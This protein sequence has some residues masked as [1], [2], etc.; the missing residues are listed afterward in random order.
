MVSIFNANVVIGKHLLNFTLTLRTSFSYK[1][2]DIVITFRDA[3]EVV[4]SGGYSEVEA[5]HMVRQSPHAGQLR[6]NGLLRVIAR[7]RQLQKNAL[8]FN[9]WRANFVI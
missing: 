7:E 1:M 3:V 9:V 8:C 6:F 2:L 5:V 4:M